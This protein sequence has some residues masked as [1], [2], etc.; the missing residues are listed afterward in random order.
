MKPGP[1][2]NV[3]VFSSGS[4]F[5]L[6]QQ[7]VFHRSRTAVFYGHNPYMQNAVCVSGEGATRPLLTELMT[8]RTNPIRIITD[9]AGRGPGRFHVQRPG[10]VRFMRG[11]KNGVATFSDKSK[12]IYKDGLLH[13]TFGPAIRWPDGTK[14]W[15]QNGKMHRIGGPAMQIGKGGK[16]GKSWYWNGLLHRTD[17]PAVDFPDGY[18]AWFLYGKEIT[19]DF[20]KTLTQGPENDLILY[21]GKGYDRYIEE[22]LKNG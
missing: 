4:P 16:R 3:S 6:N 7:V 9:V 17:G 15:Y 19:E 20:F 8:N 11:P 12:A 14:H 1:E 5:P 13:C 21:L 18:K 2:D 22:R 10:T